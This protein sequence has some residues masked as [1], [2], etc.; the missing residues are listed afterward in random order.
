MNKDLNRVKHIKKYCEEI[1]QTI[2][3]YGDTFDV[4]E[5]DK[6]YYKSVTMSLFQI[7][8]LSVGL[9]DSFKS[10]T[11]NEIPW[12]S[13]RALRNMFAHEYGK[14]DTEIIWNTLH[15][16]IPKLQQ[17]CENIIAKFE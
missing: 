2:N 10:N 15:T 16:D 13:I 5:A 3:R 6:D 4:F 14:L 12:S 11:D 17:F 8:E 1:N 9:S 7:G